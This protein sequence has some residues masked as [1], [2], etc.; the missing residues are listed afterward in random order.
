MKLSIFSSILLS[1]GVFALPSNVAGKQFWVLALW[2]S[3]NSGDE[4]KYLKQMLT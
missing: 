4:T 1:S 2:L 3:S